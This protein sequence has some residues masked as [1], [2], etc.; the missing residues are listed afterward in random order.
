MV[1]KTQKEIDPD[2][3][4]Q[5]RF[6]NEYRIILD[7]QSGLVAAK[8]EGERRGYVK[9]AVNTIKSFKMTVNEAIRILELAQEYH[10]DITTELKKQN[11]P[12]TE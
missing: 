4:E 8:R 9:V 1:S 5:A 12:Y 7:Y 11:I 2:E 3:N 10:D 6:L